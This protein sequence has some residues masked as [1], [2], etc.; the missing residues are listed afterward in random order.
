M[1]DE[2]SQPRLH[3]GWALEEIRKE[4]LDLHSIGELEERVR[5][6]EAEI[7]RARGAIRK[8]SEGRAAADAVFFRP[9]AG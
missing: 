1:M 7:E 4:D 8:K 2:P 5:M 9:G 3:R 6:L